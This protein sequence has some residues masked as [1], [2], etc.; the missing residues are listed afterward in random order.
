MQ[1]EISFGEEKWTTFSIQGKQGKE[2]KKGREGMNGKER[3]E[4][5]NL[6]EDNSIKLKVKVIFFKKRV[7]DPPPRI[8]FVHGS[9]MYH[10]D[11]IGH[12]AAPP[13][14]PSLS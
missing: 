6:Y 10:I 9:H 12:V 1:G 11:M 4:K 8:N 7:L 14:H 3:E 5:E 13:G 2:G